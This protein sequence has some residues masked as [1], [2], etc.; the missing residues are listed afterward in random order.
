MQM[1]GRRKVELQH[2]EGKW[3]AS[4][5]SCFTPSNTAPSTQWTGD[6]V[7]P[8]TSLDAVEYRSLAYAEHQTLNIQPIRII[9][10]TGLLQ[11]KGLY[12]LLLI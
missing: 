4:H 5:S 9:I 11:G 7:G 12:K 8:G 3:L 1:Y 6:S 10:L 2:S